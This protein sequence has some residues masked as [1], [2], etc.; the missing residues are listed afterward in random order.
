MIC[1]LC[2][3][4]AICLPAPEPLNVPLGINWPACH[5]GPPSTPKVPNLIRSSKLD[6]LNSNDAVLNGFGMS[7]A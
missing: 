4:P 2:E 3:H 7:V 5:P 1:V 6:L